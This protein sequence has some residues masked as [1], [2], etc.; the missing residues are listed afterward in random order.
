MLKKKE[1]TAVPSDLMSAYEDREKDHHH[2]LTTAVASS[3]EL[4]I[5]VC[6]SPSRSAALGFSDSSSVSSLGRNRASLT[7][8]IM[9]RCAMHHY[10][11]TERATLKSH[12]I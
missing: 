1:K 10:L 4:L 2:G 12:T 7:C 5:H 3:F 8:Q 6:V 11:M 9:L